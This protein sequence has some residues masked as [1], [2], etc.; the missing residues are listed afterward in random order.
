MK[1]ASEG[2]QFYKKTLIMSAIAT[3][4]E[5]CLFLQRA[6]VGIAIGSKKLR[7]KFQYRK[8]KLLWNSFNEN[9]LFS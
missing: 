1:I 5:K 9:A 4:C 8:N 3:A 6:K 7:I 2:M